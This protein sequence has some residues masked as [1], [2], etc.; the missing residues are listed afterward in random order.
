M[1]MR[2][3]VTFQMVL[4]LS[5]SE[6]FCRVKLKI[7]AMVSHPALFETAVSPSTGN[8]RGRLTDCMMT[9]IDE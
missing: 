5:Y 8:A 7:P 1:G 3:F 2:Y 6:D 9:K 4:S